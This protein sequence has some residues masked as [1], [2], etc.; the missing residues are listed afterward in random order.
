MIRFAKR[1]AEK[2]LLGVWKHPTPIHVL[3]IEDFNA[4]C[5]IA[6][7]RSDIQ[8][9]YPLGDDA[10][11]TLQEFLDTVCAR[12][13]LAKPWRVPV[14]SVYTV[15]WLCETAARLFRTR[16]PFTIDFI[17]IGRVPYYCDTRRMKAELLPTLQYPTLQEGLALLS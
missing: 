2:K 8:G 3:S 17:R 15:A 12:W 13:G 6:L 4:C 5:R 16:T 11:T 9:I 7:E 14:W 10:P 1:L